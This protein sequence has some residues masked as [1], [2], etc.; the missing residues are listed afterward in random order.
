[1][2]D[3]VEQ[4]VRTDLWLQRTNARATISRAISMLLLVPV[5][6]VTTIG[7]CA[8]TESFLPLIFA[9]LYTVI[10]GFGGF[11]LLSLGLVRNQ[12]AARELAR[13]DERYQLPEA[14]VVR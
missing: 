10:G 6:V 3:L 4:E 7:I 1:M 5:V 12:L 2:A 11:V 8:A 14:R 9:A 13:L